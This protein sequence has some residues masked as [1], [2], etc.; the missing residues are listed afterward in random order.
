MPEYFLYIKE[1]LNRLAAS[2]TLLKLTFNPPP[3]P[4][5]IA[6]PGTKEPLES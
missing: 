1:K 6:L 4:L 5:N 3:P 2:K